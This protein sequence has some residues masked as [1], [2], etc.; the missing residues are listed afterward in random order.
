MFRPFPAREVRAALRGVRQVAIIDRN[1]S[2]GS[3]GIFSQEI[4]ACLYGTEGATPIT[5]VIGG[6][7][8]VDIT[9]EHIRR[10]VED[11]MRQRHKE[12]DAIWMEAQP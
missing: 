5:S 8:G 6:L 4:R 7:G 2:P 3:G 11:L 12:V 1:L 10:L 9:P